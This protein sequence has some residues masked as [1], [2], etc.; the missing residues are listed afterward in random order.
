MEAED[1]GHRHGNFPNYYSF[2]PPQ[3]RLHILEQCGLM[4]Y[5]R[6]G[7]VVG[8][9]DV[10]DLDEDRS[11]LISPRKK[12]RLDDDKASCL[13]AGKATND[14]MAEK[15]Y[16]IYYCD[17]GCNEGDLTMA[18]ASS[19]RKAVHNNELS[20]RCLGLDIDETLVQRASKKFSGKYADKSEKQEF[21]PVFRDCNLCSNDEHNN[22][23]SSFFSNTK[24]AQQEI[25]PRK[26]FF[27]TTIFSATMWIHI[28]AGD[29]GLTK[30]LERACGWTKKY[31]LIE[32]QH[33]GW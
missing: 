24:N 19:L 28:H 17:L 16:I 26:M 15:D 18:M 23:C 32:P 10:S 22:A 4:T 6:R 20:V 12:A 1:K 29:D 21:M 27:L 5:M 25:I 7:L 30:F 31:L 11:K 33:S 14:L 3:N 8:A 9:D 13:A 2:H